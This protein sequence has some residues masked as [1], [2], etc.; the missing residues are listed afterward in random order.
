MIGSGNVATQLAHAFSNAGLRI[1]EIHSLHAGHAKK[2][3]TAV[4]AKAVANIKDLSSDT[5]LFLIAVNDDRIESVAGSL[6]HRNKLTV[7]TSGATDIDVFASYDFTGTGVFYP[8]QSLSAD[9][10]VNFSNIPLCIE[11]NNE[12]HTELLLE[13]GRQLS[14]QVV[15]VSSEHRK[16]L[17]LA[18]VFANNFTNHLYAIA[19]ELLAEHDLSFDMLK[20]LITRTAEKV[21]NAS[22]L[23]RQTGP[24][25]RNDTAI[26]EKHVNMLKNEAYKELYKLFNKSILQMKKV[27]SIE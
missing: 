13:L 4:G 19:G 6:P 22:P 15:K 1:G 18:A 20:P 24:A 7:H 27:Y 3:A 23:S 25:I 5:D 17:H 16:I 26:M 11:G 2:L 10:P 21:Q 12:F 8:L 9:D 14:E